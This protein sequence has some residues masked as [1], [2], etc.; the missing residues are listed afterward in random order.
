MELNA[1]PAS[2]LRLVISKSECV[3]VCP[4]PGAA[5]PQSVIQA[6][7]VAAAAGEVVG[8]VAVAQL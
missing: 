4:C 3:A 6:R 5:A 1:H 2:A 8:G 7:A